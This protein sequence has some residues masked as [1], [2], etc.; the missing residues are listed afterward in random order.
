VCGETTIDGKLCCV[1]AMLDER[2]LLV[3]TAPILVN[4]HSPCVLPSQRAHPCSNLTCRRT[5]S[6]SFSFYCLQSFL[7]RNKNLLT[8]PP[9]PRT[10]TGDRPRRTPSFVHFPLHY[11]ARPRP[12]PRRGGRVGHGV[13]FPGTWSSGGAGCASGIL[14]R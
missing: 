8:P 4:L 2:G 3:C 12:S 6:S 10:N 9:H 7:F 11:H 13:C 14:F 5:S 1:L